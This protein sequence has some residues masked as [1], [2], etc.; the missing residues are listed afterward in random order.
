[1]IC[2]PLLESLLAKIL[3]STQVP[4]RQP[5]F[6]E[7]AERRIRNRKQA[8]REIRFAHAGEKDTTLSVLRR[9]QN[10]VPFSAFPK[11]QK[12]PFCAL[13]IL[14]S[15]LCEFPQL[16]FAHRIDLLSKILLIAKNVPEAVRTDSSDARRLDQPF[17]K[18][19]H[20]DCS[21]PL[22]L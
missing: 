9:K 7:K 18:N 21:F 17:G 8:L 22:F 11:C 4:R 10:R 19:T 12:T 1:M 2:T 6:I 13:L 3:A 5:A 15:F 14:K 16:L 20:T